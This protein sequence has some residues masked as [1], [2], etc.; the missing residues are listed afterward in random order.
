[1]LMREGFVTELSELKEEIMLLGS[2]VEKAFKDVVLALEHNNNSMFDKV[3]ENDQYVNSLE[4]NINEK[5]TLLIMKQQP[6][7]SDL[8]RI[9]V[10]LK[11]SS[12][13]ERVGDLAVDMAKSAKRMQGSKNLDINQEDLMFMAHTTQEMLRDVLN[14]YLNGNV[15]EAQRIANKDDDVDDAY[16]K[17]VKSI[18]KVVSDGKETTE[19][20]AQLAF[21]ARY[22]ERIADYCTNIAE[23]IIYEVNGERFDLN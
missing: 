19:L 9:I 21:I 8:R 6:V 17:F 10:A 7:A 13:L 15:I 5:A 18:F 16:G 20:I 1:M 23:W 4:L 14:A 22:I 11:V 3:I 2:M 12:D